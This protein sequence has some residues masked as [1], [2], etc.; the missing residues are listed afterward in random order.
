M[1]DKQFNKIM[2]RKNNLFIIMRDYILDEKIHAKMQYTS[3]QK[4]FSFYNEADALKVL[5][6]LYKYYRAYYYLISFCSTMKNNKSVNIYTFKSAIK[7]LE[8]NYF[9]DVYFEQWQILF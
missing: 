7:Y 8:Q 1:N 2:E 3:A 4:C 6:Y 5:K 9:Y